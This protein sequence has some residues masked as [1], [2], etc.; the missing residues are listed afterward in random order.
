MKHGFVVSRRA[1]QQ[2][3]DPSRYCSMALVFCFCI[4]TPSCCIQFVQCQH[5]DIPEPPPLGVSI[6][7][8]ACHLLFENGGGGNLGMHLP[9]QGC[10][11]LRL[12]LERDLTILE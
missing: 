1:G 9:Q 7:S 4:G 2:G 3:D 6:T 5:R 11:L 8:P 10:A 12:I